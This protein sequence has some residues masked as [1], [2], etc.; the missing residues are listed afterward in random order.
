MIRHIVLFKLKDARPHKV[1]AAA[2]MLRSMRGK[3]EG[4]LEIEAGCDFLGSERS[5][6]LA[7]TC[8]F[9]SEESFNAYVDHPVHKPVKAYMHA[10]RESSVACD[11]KL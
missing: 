5:F 7:L 9:D 8:T 2:E 3:I 11:Y 6:D 4:L 10:V 1:E